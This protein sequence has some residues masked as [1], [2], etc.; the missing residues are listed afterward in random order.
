MQCI[1]SHKVCDGSL[2]YGCHDESDESTRL[3]GCPGEDEWPCH[4]GKGCVRNTEVCDG[5]SGCAD[6]SDE[7]SEFCLIWNCTETME[8]CS[9]NIQC[10]D[11]FIFC[12][13]KADCLDKSDEEDCNSYSCPSGTTKCADNTCDNT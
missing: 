1:K 6:K 7:Y 2:H 12:D 10:V 4:N 3:C 5:I 8:K 11:K 13:G 9:N